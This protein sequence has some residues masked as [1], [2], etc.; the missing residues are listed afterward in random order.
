VGWGVD[1]RTAA[2]SRPAPALLRTA[3]AAALLACFAVLA[4]RH[5][6]GQDV[7][8]DEGFAFGAGRAILRQGSWDGVILPHP[9]LSYYVSSLPLFFIEGEASARDPRQLLLCRLATLF[10]FGLPLLL[11]VRAWAE[12]L[13]S[14]GAGLLALALAAFSPTLLAHAPL[15]TPD[16]PLAATG[17]LTL[18]LYWRAGPDGRVWP[19][20][21]ALGLTLLTK[22]TGVL[23]VAALAVLE[24][25]RARERGLAR[26]SRRLLAAAALAWLVLNL[27]YGFAGLFDAEG[28][29]ALL[30]KVPPVPGLRPAA[31]AAAPFFPLPYLRCVARQAHTGTEGWPVYLLGEVRMGGWWYYY[32]VALAVKETLPSLLLLAGALLSLAWLRPS[33]RDEPVL[34]VP[35][36]LFFAFF[37]MGGIQIGIRYVLPALPLLFVFAARVVRLRWAARPAFQPA[38]VA[39]LAGHAVLS[40]RGGPDYL[41][42]FNELAGGPAGGWRYLGDSNLDWGQNRSP[43]EEFARRTGAAFEPLVLPSHGRVVL[44]TNRVQGFMDPPRYRLLR[45]EYL[46]A[47]R[48]GW[49]WF[50]YDLDRGRRFPAESMVTVVSGT[51]WL[52]GPASGEG[53]TGSSFDA[54]AWRPATVAAVNEPAAG[55][56]FPG[57]AARVMTCAEGAPDCAFRRSFELRTAP[58]QAILYLATRGDYE[59]YANGR[60]VGAG[61]GCRRYVRTERHRLTEA[62][63]PGGNVLAL[64]AGRCGEATPRALV[65]MRVAQ[66]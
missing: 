4:L 39:L 19:W 34:L 36:L 7:T 50:L 49:N 42:Y 66:E 54:R 45:D 52:S 24:L 32:L 13:Y 46:P 58:A 8:Y 60:R 29:A 56:A 14:P 2:L 6:D 27:G 18:Y 28:K 43:A 20:G 31:H 11:T 64:R 10:A 30:A 38:L 26:A 33:A 21:V 37:S 48:V 25:A 35:A 51:E 5:V 63:R 53:W 1:E 65:E 44:S 59:L 23:F 40:V 16:V 55:E 12:R 57:S 41:A 62:L 61:P 9:P 15:V 22:V 17:L 47:G 3:G